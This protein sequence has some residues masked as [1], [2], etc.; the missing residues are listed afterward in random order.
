MLVRPVGG[1]LVALAGRDPARARFHAATLR[2]RVLGY[3]TAGP[4]A[5]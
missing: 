2:G 5:R 3:L 1:A 4:T